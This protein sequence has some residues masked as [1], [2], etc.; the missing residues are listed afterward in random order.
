M[1]TVESVEF[2][3]PCW[4]RIQVKELNRP[5]MLH[6]NWFLSRNGLVP[7]PDGYGQILIK[8]GDRVRFELAKYPVYLSDKES[9]YVRN[10]QVVG[11]RVEEVDVDVSI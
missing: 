10:F 1:A 4:F 7:G 5:I 6:T 2:V 9:L 11:Q 8:P 3:P